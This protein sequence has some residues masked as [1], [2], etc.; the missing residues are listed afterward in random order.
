MHVGGHQGDKSS[1]NESLNLDF[2][3]FDSIFVETE[4]QFLF[5]LKEK[6]KTERTL[7]YSIYPVYFVDI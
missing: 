6:Q 5:F 1:Q 2:F 4:K 3:P 7:T